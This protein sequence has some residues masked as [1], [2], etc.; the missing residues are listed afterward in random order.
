[1][2]GLYSAIIEWENLRRAFW[3]ASRG[4]KKKPAVIE[5]SRNLDANIEALRQSLLCPSRIVI[6]NYRFF[7]IYDPKERMICEAPFE[8]RVLHHA[9]MNILEPYF[10]AFQTNDSFACRKGR[11]TDAA[12]RAA[13]HHARRHPIYLKVDI[14]KYYDSLP[15]DTL[16]ALLARKFKD[17]RL[18]LLLSRLIDSYSTAPN[19]G[20]PIGNLTSQYFANFYLGFLDHAVKESIP[21]VGYVR[22]MDDIIVCMDSEEQRM[23]VLHCIESFCASHGLSLKHAHRGRCTDGAPFLGFLVRPSGIF[24]SRAKRLRARKRALLYMDNFLK[25]LWDE[26]E[27]A[28]HYLPFSAHLSIARSAAFRAKLLSMRSLGE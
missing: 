17:A 16:K 18:L 20:I 3:R 19:R 6:G 24:L 26:E 15:H 10:D 23:R 5:Y 22:Y 2:G 1:V 21:G 12:L 11:G 14:R 27:F 7:R 28:L 13:L 4:K 9:V 25:G 8:E